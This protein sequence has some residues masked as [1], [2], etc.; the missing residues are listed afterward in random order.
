MNY[1]DELYNY[2]MSQ[3]KMYHTTDGVQTA[4]KGLKKKNVIFRVSNKVTH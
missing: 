4:A 3:S 1:A 2:P